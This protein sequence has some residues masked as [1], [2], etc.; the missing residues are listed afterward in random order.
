[1]ERSGLGQANYEKNSFIFQSAA[2]VDIIIVV[3][4]NCKKTKKVCCT[5]AKCLCRRN[6]SKCISA[7]GH[8]RGNGSDNNSLCSNGKESYDDDVLDNIFGIMLRY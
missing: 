8:C 3:R 5:L 7:C 2:P 1:M 4:C 6:G